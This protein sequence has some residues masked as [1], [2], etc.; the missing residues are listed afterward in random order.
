M[1]D[2]P[3]L[4]INKDQVR[5]VLASLY[6]GRSKGDGRRYVRRILH[7]FGGGATS[8]NDLLPSY[9]G[10][11]IAAV[12]PPIARISA[13]P[14]LTPDPSPEKIYGTTT[15]I[16][17][18]APA[19]QMHYGVVLDVPSKPAPVISTRIKSPLTIELEARLKERAGKPRSKPNYVVNTGNASRV[20]DQADDAPQPE[21]PA[22]ERM[23]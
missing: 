11:V 5:A 23:K 21:Y 14:G 19:P 6:N 2:E 13:F 3:S 4:I 15:D 7:R 16:G 18:G 1:S 17:E 22:G 12:G 20:G 8:I 9:Y 10:A